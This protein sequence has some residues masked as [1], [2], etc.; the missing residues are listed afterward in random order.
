MREKERSQEF[1]ITDGPLSPL[2]GTVNFSLA[3]P[4]CRVNLFSTFCKCPPRSLSC[5]SVSP[6]FGTPGTR[7]EARTPIPQQRGPEPVRLGPPS[8]PPGLSPSLLVS[9]RCA[10]TIFPKGSSATCQKNHFP[11]QRSGQ[12]PRFT[13]DPQAATQPATPPPTSPGSGHGQG[14]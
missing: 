12:P 8:G 5:V 2:W 7:E 14:P 6:S 9:S 11:G 1:W 13:E 3:A 10:A 4:P